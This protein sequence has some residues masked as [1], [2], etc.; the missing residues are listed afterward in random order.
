MNKSP[1]F[2]EPKCSLPTPQE[3]A[4]VVPIVCHDLLLHS[5]SFNTI[6]YLRLHL[7]NSP[8][9]SGLQTKK[10]YSFLSSHMRG[11]DTFLSTLFATTHPTQQQPYSRE[12]D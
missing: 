11:A 7:P 6:P 4:S 1:A 5:N 3:P 12:C 8:F 2:L 10:L 9:S